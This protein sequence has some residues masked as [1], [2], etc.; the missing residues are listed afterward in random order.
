EQWAREKR[1]L[2]DRLQWAEESKANAET[3]VNFFREQYQTAS[4]FASTTRAENDD[5]LTRAKLAE[6]QATYGVALLR[7]T[8]DTRIAKLEREVAKYKALVELLTERARRTDDEV[9]LR[10]A[11]EPE[12]R[13]E[14]RTLRADLEEA[15][16]E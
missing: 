12:L 7:A 4:A 16:E 10:A 3:D 8:F 15:R 6:S 1:R 11:L 14:N 9:R 5:L 2:Q 13:R